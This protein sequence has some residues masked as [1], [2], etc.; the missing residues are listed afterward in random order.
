MHHGDPHGAARRSPVWRAHAERDTVPE[1]DD[2]MPDALPNARWR[3]E[4]WNRFGDIQA[5]PL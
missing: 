5:W 3:V 4:S 2:A 1:L